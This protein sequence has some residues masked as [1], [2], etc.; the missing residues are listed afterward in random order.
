MAAT[1]ATASK[2]STT[3]RA[4]TP[5]GSTT[6]GGNTAGQSHPVLLQFV[7][8]F[9]LILVAAWFSNISDDTG[10]VG[11]ALFALLWLLWLMNNSSKLKGITP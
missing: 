4:S 3:T 8:G 2:P 5:S 10:N 11:A 7:V 1:N 9:G 6:S